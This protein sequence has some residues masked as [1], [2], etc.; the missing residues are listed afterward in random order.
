MSTASIEESKEHS[1]AY[2]T[3]LD[4]PDLHSS[5]IREDKALNREKEKARIHEELEVLVK[6]REDLQASQ[7]NGDSAVQQAS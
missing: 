5:D 1:S 6:L 7:K 4:M 3:I 2:L